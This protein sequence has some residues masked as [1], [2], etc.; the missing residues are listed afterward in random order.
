MHFSVSCMYTDI[1]AH[2]CTHTLMCCLWYLQNF[3]FEGISFYLRFLSNFLFPVDRPENYIRWIVH[4]RTW[5]TPASVVFCLRDGRARVICFPLSH[6]S[7][8][9]GR[10]WL[11]VVWEKARIFTEWNLSYRQGR[12]H[13]M[14]SD[15]RVIILE[16]LHM[17]HGV[18]EII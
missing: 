18:S 5:P 11:V 17:K 1:Q 4:S 12:A 3:K 6:A 13:L 9:A 2:M 16:G 10:Q 15:E 14:C 8:V 7:C